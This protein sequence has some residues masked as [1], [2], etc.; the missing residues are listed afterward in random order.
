MNR[1]LTASNS[2]MCAI[3]A[4]WN[5]NTFLYKICIIYMNHFKYIFSLLITKDINVIITI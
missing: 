1:N 4:H 2:S 3:V 5:I